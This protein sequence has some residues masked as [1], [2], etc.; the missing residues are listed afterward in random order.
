[1]IRNHSYRSISIY[2][3]GAFG[4]CTAAFVRQLITAHEEVND[5]DVWHA[6][7]C[8]S[9]FD[10]YA[11]RSVLRELQNV[12]SAVICASI[13]DGVLVS[14][15]LGPESICF[16]CFYKR[17]IASL[18]SW[19]YPGHREQVLTELERNSPSLREL[20]LPE[21][22]AQ[23]AASAVLRQLWQRQRRPRFIH[24]HSVSG[25][26]EHGFVLPLHECETCHSDRADS[27]YSASIRDCFDADLDPGKC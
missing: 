13:H 20:E 2:S 17:W 1:M 25:V 23:V 12:E 21:I 27:R 24:I 15:P 6:A 16:D 14:P 19:A 10:V 26:V 22:H 9:S 7:I 5:S 11:A 18:Q 3:K 4:E 8:L